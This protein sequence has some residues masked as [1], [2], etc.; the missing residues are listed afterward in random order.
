MVQKV[1]GSKD[2]V[3]NTRVFFQTGEGCKTVNGEGW[4]LSFI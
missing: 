4:A 1:A 2:S 3:S